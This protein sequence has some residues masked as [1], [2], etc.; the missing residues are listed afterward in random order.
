MKLQWKRKQ[1]RHAP[2]RRAPKTRPPGREK[3]LLNGPRYVCTR[4]FEQDMRCRMRSITQVPCL[5]HLLLPETT[6]GERKRLC[7]VQYCAIVCDIVQYCAKANLSKTTL[8]L[9]GRQSSFTSFLRRSVG[10]NGWN[11]V[12][13][14]LLLHIALQKNVFGVVGRFEVTIKLGRLQ[15]DSNPRPSAY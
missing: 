9:Y 15:G 13:M 3:G 1:K 2:K 11:V 12:T 7:I 5:K 10:E 14:S 4:Q 6:N 8:C